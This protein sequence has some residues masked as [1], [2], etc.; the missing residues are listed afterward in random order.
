VPF[1]EFEKKDYED[2][3]SEIKKLFNETL[4]A[5]IDTIDFKY[6]EKDK[7]CKVKFNSIYETNDLMYLIRKALIENNSNFLNSLDVQYS[8]TELAPKIRKT[9]NSKIIIQSKDGEKCEKICV[10]ILK[11]LKK[12]NKELEV[13]WLDNPSTQKIYKAEINF[14]KPGDFSCYGNMLIKNQTTEDLKKWLEPQLKDLNL[15]IKFTNEKCI[16]LELK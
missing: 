10:E 3:Q 4:N 12:D 7:I 11:N 13:Y 14:L 15:E 2:H 9:L 1:Y 5:P 8:M 6:I 16:L